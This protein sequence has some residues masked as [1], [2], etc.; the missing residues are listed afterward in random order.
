[1]TSAD[2]ARLTAGRAAL[3]ATIA[4]RCR[5]AA[6]F[7]RDRSTAAY[8]G[9]SGADRA[10]APK[11]DILADVWCLLAAGAHPT[12][13]I[14]WATSRWSWYRDANHARVEAAAKIKRGPMSGHSAI[15]HEWVADSIAADVERVVTTVA[16]WLG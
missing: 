9:A 13:V 8:A 2:F 10:D 1:M 14:E 11:H 15:S 4:E 6:R 7:A 12:P 3:P 5:D 16:G